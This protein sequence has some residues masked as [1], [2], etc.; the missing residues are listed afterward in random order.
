VHGQV[1]HRQR[2]LSLERQELILGEGD[3]VGHAVPGHNHV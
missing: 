1:H 3:V 2:P